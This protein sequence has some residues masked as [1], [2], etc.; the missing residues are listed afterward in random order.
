[1]KQAFHIHFHRVYYQTNMIFFPR[2]QIL[3]RDEKKK[4]KKKK[5]KTYFTIQDVTWHK[6]D[7]EHQRQP[8]R[9]HCGKPSTTIWHF[10]WQWSEANHRFPSA[11]LHLPLSYSEPCFVSC[12]LHQP[13]GSTLRQCLDS[14]RPNNLG[15]PISNPSHR[16]IHSGA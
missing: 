14:G 16:V 11:L 15:L 7:W 2:N 3:I 10:Y 5:K 6:A 12:Y 13:K 1:M 9:W 8:W 4:K